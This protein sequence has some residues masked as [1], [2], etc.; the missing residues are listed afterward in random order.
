MWARHA[1]CNA[2]SKEVVASGGVVELAAIVTLDTADIG[3]KLGA[4][5]GKKVG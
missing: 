3:F 1:E 2:M 5:M 4:S